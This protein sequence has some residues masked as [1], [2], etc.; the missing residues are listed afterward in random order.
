MGVSRDR[1]VDFCDKII[2]IFVYVLIFSLP[3]STALVEISATFMIFAWLT[4]RAFGY[5]SFKPVLTYLNVSIFVFILA[6]FLSVIFSSNL[7]LSL[8]NFFSKTLEYIFL[9]FIVAEFACDKRRL[10]NI[11]IIMLSSLAMIGTD[12]IFQYFFGFDFLRHRTLEAGRITA[13][14]RMPG[15][16]A[17]YLGPMLCLPLTLCF[18]KFKKGIKYFLRIESILLLAVLI[19]TVAR[20]AWIGFIAAVCFLGWVEN[21]KIFWVTGVSLLILIILMPHLIGP[22]GGHFRP[23]KKYCFSFR[24]FLSGQKG[25][26][27]GSGADDKG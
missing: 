22:G 16:L 23:F 2:E 3:F 21:K 10:K 26:L 18:L 7:S 4:K 12:C 15:D 25:H 5:R 24:R 11:V 9:F 27:A 13:S 19:V 17:G 20:G 1:I 14:F 6:T 8:K